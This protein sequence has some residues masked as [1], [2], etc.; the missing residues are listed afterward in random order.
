MHQLCTQVVIPSF[1]LFSPAHPGYCTWPLR[2]GYHDVCFRH[3][4]IPVRQ[5]NTS[6][7]GYCVLHLSM[8]LT[9][10]FICNT[11]SWKEQTHSWKS[12][13]ALTHL[14]THTYIYKRD[15]QLFS[16]APNL[17][18]GAQGE[19]FC[20]GSATDPYCMIFFNQGTVQSLPLVGKHKA[21]S[22]YFWAKCLCSRCW[23][24]PSFS[25]LPPASAAHCWRSSLHL[26]CR[27]HLLSRFPSQHVLLFF[28]HLFSVALSLPTQRLFG[29]N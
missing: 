11:G 17:V 20:S 3:Q 7:C 24:F 22:S 16:P 2:L 26:V 10:S 19:E 9:L 21:Y 5:C 28:N 1:I 27:L 29:R 13:N 12:G 15:N 18:F 8:T 25:L 14:H 23:V 4:T 6:W